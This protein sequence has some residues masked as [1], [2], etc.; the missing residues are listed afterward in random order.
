MDTH[1]TISAK[2][3]NPLEERIGYKFRNSLLLAEALTHPSLSLERRSYPFDNQRLEF[4]GDAVIQL[5]V[6]DHLYRTFPDF[7]EGQLTKLRTRVVSRAA[8]RAQALDLQLGEVLMMGK[9]E[10]ASGGRLRASTLADA[11]E[12]LSGAIYLDG[13]FARAQE[14]VLRKMAAA[15][16]MLEG[17]PLEVNPKGVLQE[18][19]QAIAPNAPHYVLLS[20]S[21]PDHLRVFECSVNWEGIELAQ[22]IGRS[23]KQAEVAAAAEA[24]ANRAWEPYKRSGAAAAKTKP[25]KRKKKPKPSPPAKS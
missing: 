2:I 19:L 25:A 10:E 4:L 22:G 15:L 9:G 17:E 20:Q 16:S 11:F 23:K 21:G 3:M 6:T 7:S 14:F 8:L 18:I 12:S 1:P 13:G 24:L 5:I